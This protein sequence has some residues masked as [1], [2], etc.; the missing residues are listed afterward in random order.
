MQDRETATLWSHVTGEAMEGKLAGTRLAM[1]PSVQTTWKQWFKQYPGTKVLKKDTEITSSRYER[2]FSDPDRAGMFRSR[3]LMDRMPGKKRVF[4][5]T[6]GP[7]ALAI[8]EEKIMSGRVL[9]ADVGGKPV[10]VVVSEDGGVKG[11]IAQAGELELTF[12]AAEN[13]ALMLDEETRS[14]WAMSTGVCVEGRLE[15]TALDEVLV[16]RAF[17]FAWSSFYPNT[18]VID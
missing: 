17:W 12:I 10:V 18:L 3:W 15:R 16:R 4:G 11:Y 9:N 8:A 5:L 7:H 13:G 6:N 1:L 14:K 2:Y